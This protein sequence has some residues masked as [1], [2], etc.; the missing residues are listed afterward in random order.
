MLIFAF[1][2]ASENRC[3]PHAL[4]RRASFQAQAIWRNK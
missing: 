1:L 3:G 4:Q 2:A